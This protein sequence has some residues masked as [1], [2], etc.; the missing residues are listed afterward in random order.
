MQDLARRAGEQRD[1]AAFHINL[2]LCK[3]I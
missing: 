2:L 3:R 1:P